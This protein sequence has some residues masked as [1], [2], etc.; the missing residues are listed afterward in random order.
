MWTTLLE[1][2]NP[3]EA[4]SASGQRESDEPKHEKVKEEKK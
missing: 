3:Y 4:I 2:L 1:I